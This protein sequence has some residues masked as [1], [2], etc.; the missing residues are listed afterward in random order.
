M[1]ASQPL[2]ELCSSRPL[3]GLLG[4]LRNV[5]GSLLV[6][7]HVDIA[8]PDRL[9]FLGDGQMVLANR[10]NQ[11]LLPNK[12]IVVHLVYVTDEVGGSSAVGEHSGVNRSSAE[13]YASPRPVY[14]AAIRLE[15]DIQVG[16]LAG[17]DVDVLGGNFVAIV[18]DGHGVLPGGE[19]NSAL[20]AFV[21]GFSVNKNI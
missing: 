16:R 21:D 3:D 14:S 8:F 7:L 5:D 19:R 11:F 13:I 18:H 20:P 9:A 10:E 4:V 17:C 12:E 6:R 1:E 2:G 15:H